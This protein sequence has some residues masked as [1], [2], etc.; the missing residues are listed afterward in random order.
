MLAKSQVKRK[1]ATAEV[2][3]EVLRV[4]V[5]QEVAGNQGGRPVQGKGESRCAGL[6]MMML[7]QEVWEYNQNQSIARSRVKKFSS[8][9]RP[10]S[11]R[12]QILI[13]SVC[14]LCIRLYSDW[15]HGV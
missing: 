4:E 6:F 15:L 14:I 8:V 9:H 1:D 7:F 13:L 10:T 5:G 2:A 11:A 12:L 3:P